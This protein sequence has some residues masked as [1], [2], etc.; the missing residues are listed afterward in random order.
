MILKCLTEVTTE[1][2]K[3]KYI[4]LHSCEQN[5]KIERA[6]LSEVVK[7]WIDTT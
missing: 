7:D 4:R 6:G 3:G 1:D 2:F 5:F